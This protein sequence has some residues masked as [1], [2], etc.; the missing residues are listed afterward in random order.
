MRKT[1]AS[2]LI[3]CL[4]GCFSPA[5]PAG[6][7]CAPVGAAE[8]C[9]AGLQCI[10]GGG[11]ETC[12]SLGSLPDAS[13]DHAVDAA[14]DAEVDGDHDSDGV[15]DSV[16]NCPD[17]ANASQSDED[18]DHVGDLC[19][20]CPPFATNTDAD[21]DGVGD[22]CDPNPATAGDTIVAFE[23]FATVLPA[24]WTST[25]TFS[26]ASGDGVLSAAENATSLLTRASPAAAGVEI[27]AAFV[28][29]EI[30]ASGLFLG[31]V[32]VIERMKPSTDKAVACQLA[33]LANGAQEYVRI[34]DLNAPA[35]IATKP[36]GFASGAARELRL[37]RNGTSYACRVASP[38]A[39]VA[40]TVGFAPASP[41]IGLRVH[42]AVARF[43]WVMIV[44]SP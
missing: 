19:D 14:V 28:L 33:G 16:D 31:S 18:G 37:G 11:V 9:P 44:T 29:D 3:A 6:A 27:R 21:G 4:G 5:A 26:I 12:E 35:V 17:V 39:D 2:I 13:S 34:F 1:S 30:T 38:Q 15:I 40:G 36:Y 23:G 42:G 41:R 32:N 10:V 24:G 8:R 7:P 43:R 25:G 20:P 22:A